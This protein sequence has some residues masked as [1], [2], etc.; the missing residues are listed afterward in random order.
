MT[1]YCLMITASLWVRNYGSED[2]AVLLVGWLSRWGNSR[3]PQSRPGG[4]QHGG[5]CG[6]GRVR[7]VDCVVG[8]STALVLS[9]SAGI[10]AGLLLSSVWSAL[11]SRTSWIWGV[12]VA[13]KPP[14]GGVAK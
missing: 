11:A 9:V 5:R 3:R 6:A 8:A 7:D 12:R 13:V 1:G 4:Q 10:C 2:S 14:A